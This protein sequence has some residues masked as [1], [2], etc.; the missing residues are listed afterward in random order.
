MLRSKIV[1][2]PGKAG[3]FLSVKVRH[4][5]RDSHQSIT[6]GAFAEATN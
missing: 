2:A 5:Q 6:K 4:R 1:S 3:N